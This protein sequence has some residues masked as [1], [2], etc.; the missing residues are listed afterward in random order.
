MSVSSVDSL[1]GVE[2]VKAS[3]ASC[4]FWD[5]Q[6]SVG[7]CR[8]YPAKSSRYMNCK[9]VVEWLLTNNTDWCGEHQTIPQT[10]V[11]HKESDE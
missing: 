6:L 4:K 3:C 1:G 2:D 9:A 8:R 5:G 11:K 10:P 7:E